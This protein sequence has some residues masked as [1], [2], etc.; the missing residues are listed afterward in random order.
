M[1]VLV[2]VSVKCDALMVVVEVVWVIDVR[3]GM[4]V[5]VCLIV[6]IFVRAV[7]RLV[8]NEEGMVSLV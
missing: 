2:V 4:M 8:V 1:F 7:F 5:I 6:S 3:S